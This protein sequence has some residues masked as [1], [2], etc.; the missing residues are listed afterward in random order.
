[1]TKLYAESSAVLAWLM[2]E[3]AADA[4][5]SALLGAE[6]VVASRLTIVECGRSLV[7]SA[8]TGRASEVQVADRRALLAAVAVHWAVL[9]LDDEILERARRPFPAEPLRTL[10]AL[11][12][13]SALA[14]R[15][16]TPG[17]AILS[18]DARIRSAG[19]ELGFP[20]VPEALPA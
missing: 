17:L 13:A 11:H 1:M 20:L 4:M 7:R 19:R 15:E 14:A 6:I 8:S 5:R 2:G 18:L 3:A 12:L 10:D 16:A 9:R